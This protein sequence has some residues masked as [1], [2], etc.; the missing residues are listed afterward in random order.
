MNQITKKDLVNAL[1][2]TMGMKKKDAIPAVELVFSTIAK[3][4]AKENIIDIHGFGKFTI[5]ERGERRGVNPAT[6]REMIVPASKSVKFKPSTTL[7]GEV[8]K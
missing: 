8:N 6:G 1:H 2:E 4:L 7:K 3:E 5:T